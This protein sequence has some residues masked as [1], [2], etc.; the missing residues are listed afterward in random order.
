MA[1]ITFLPNMDTYISQW[2]YGQNFA[3]SQA[4]FVSQYQQLGDDYR[5]LL[6]FDLSSIPKASTIEKAE[7]QLT[8]FRNEVTSENICVSV[9]RLLNKWLNHTI[10]W[11]TQPPFSPLWDSS[12][13]IDQTTPLG[14]KTMDI[15][16]LVRGWHEGSIP[17]NGLLLAG[18]EDN[19]DLI[20]FRS[21][22]YLYS[23]EWPKL[24]VKFVNGILE[25]IE[26]E[27][28]MIPACPDTPIIESRPIALGPR[29]KA[30][31]M[32]L[33]T[34]DSPHV[35]VK[36]QLGCDNHPDS[37]FFDTGPWHCLEPQGYPGEAIALSSSDAAE[38]A[39]VLFW[40]AGGETLTVY[41][42][43]KET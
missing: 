18:G 14:L 7:L 37:R 2:Y 28:I 41:P 20:A 26:Q 42:R 34:S 17:N 39:R 19:N 11:D 24:S 32:I 43:T 16:D 38:Y 13:P 25:I 36:V 10:N 15:S 33:N 35:K 8:L 31:F 4:L 29:K 40:G 1:S 12:M 3:H 22:N 27:K 9:H 30:T 6:Q 21:T 5:S 23:N